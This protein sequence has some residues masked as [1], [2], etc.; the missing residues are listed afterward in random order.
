MNELFIYGVDTI[1]RETKLYWVEKSS[2]YQVAKYLQLIWKPFAIK[3]Q[4]IF[5]S[6][7]V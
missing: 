5:L 1:E 2:H 3:L 4:L 7:I 6:H